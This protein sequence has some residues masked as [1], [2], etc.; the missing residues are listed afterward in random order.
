MSETVKALPV[1]ATLFGQW[2]PLA[3]RYPF[4]VVS[5]VIVLLFVLAAI[6]RAAA[7][8]PPIRSASIRS[9]G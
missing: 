4:V 2:R 9:T 7:R 6:C 1:G 5:A 8:G 3:A